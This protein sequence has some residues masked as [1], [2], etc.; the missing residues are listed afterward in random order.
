MNTLMR[1]NPE[2]FDSEFEADALLGIRTESEAFEQEEEV[3][4]IGARTRFG[5]SRSTPKGSLPKASRAARTQFNKKVGGL[6]RDQSSSWP[7][8]QR[9]RWDYPVAVPVGMALCRGSSRS[10]AAT[11]VP[12]ASPP[13]TGALPSEYVSW[14]QTTLN[15]ALGLRLP[16]DGVMNAPTRS[17]IRLFQERRGLAVNGRV[18]PETESRPP[19]GK[20]AAQLRPFRPPAA[21]E[22]PPFQPGRLQTR[23]PQTR[24]ILQTR[25][26]R[27]RRAAPCRDRQRLRTAES[28]SGEL[29]LYLIFH[30]DPPWRA[31]GGIPPRHPPQPRQR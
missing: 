21:P 29:D 14:V 15:N 11:P 28:S 10:T 23:R 31:S 17:A 3:R 22:P 24:R 19:C 8:G 30:R 13:E 5:R 6:A 27:G 2:P 26:P 7:K 12:E 1:F 18:G 9:R 4:G 16:V 20:P 25:A